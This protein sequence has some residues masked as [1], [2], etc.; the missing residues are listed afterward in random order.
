MES[1]RTSY[2]E[3]MAN[4]DS[5][6]WVKAM[7]AEMESI[8]SNQVWEVVEPLANVKPICCKWV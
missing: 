3:A 8:D 1:D 4:S 2:E 7:K 6:H 5:T